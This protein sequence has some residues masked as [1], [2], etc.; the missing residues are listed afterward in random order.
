MNQLY[1]IIYLHELQW[2]WEIRAFYILWPP[3][4]DKLGLTGC[5]LLL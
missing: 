3:E 5:L 4:T 2:N 1:S